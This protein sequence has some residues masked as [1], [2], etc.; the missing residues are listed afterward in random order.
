MKK[1]YSKLKDRTEL[2]VILTRDSVAAGDD[3]DVPHEKKIKLRPFTDPVDLAREASKNYLPNVAGT[4][5]SWVCVLNEIEISEI[6]TKE[7]QSLINEVR[8]GDK[9]NI[10]FYYKSA[11][12]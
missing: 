10:H 3:I 9:N 4:S 5:H 7:I 8:Y 6:K 11:S 12:Y 1:E 2:S